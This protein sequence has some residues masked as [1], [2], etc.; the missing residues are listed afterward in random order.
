MKLDDLARKAGISSRT[1]RYYVQR[2]LLVAPEFRGPDTRYDERHLATLR[3]I[4]ALQDRYWP[5][6]AMV[7]A[8]SHRTLAELEAIASGALV[9]PL[10][11]G[12]TPA[13]TPVPRPQNLKKEQGVRY[14]LAP[15]VELF[16][17]ADADA[18]DLVKALLALSH[19]RSQP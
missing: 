3:A 16:V 7:G 11:P 2:G 6:E 1:V 4:R 15:G 9:L 13:V 12:E 8:L 19:E 17:R 18:E 14:H 10:Q 5:L